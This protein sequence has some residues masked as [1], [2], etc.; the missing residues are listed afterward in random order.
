MFKLTSVFL[1]VMVL[2]GC[3]KASNQVPDVA[4][5]F[6]T[7]LTDPKLSGLTSAGHGVLISGY[8]V[9]GLILYKTVGGNNYVA[10]DRCST[11]N[12]QNECAVTLDAGA[13][14]ATDPCSGAKYLLEDGSPAK[15]PAT[16]SLKQYSVTVSG[17][18]IR[19]AN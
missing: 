17:N 10:Y 8:G 18:T 3:G 5:N 6:Q 14:T 19:V 7:L 2:A 4:V 16:I 12:P 13:F 1:L 9:A 11:V 15:A